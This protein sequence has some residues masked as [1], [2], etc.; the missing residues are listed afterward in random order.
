MLNDP[1]LLKEAALIGEHWVPAGEGAIAATNPATGEIIG[2]VPDLGAAETR[3]AIA[4][5]EAPFVGIMSS[6][7]GREGSRHGIEEFVEINYL[8]FGGIA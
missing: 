5:A 7:L 8:C 2:H 4:A 1:S 3:A 6:G